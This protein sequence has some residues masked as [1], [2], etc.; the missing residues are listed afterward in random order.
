MIFKLENK[1]LKKKIKGETNGN[2]KNK[3]DCFAIIDR[4]ISI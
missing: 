1:M 2:K 3:F 4:S